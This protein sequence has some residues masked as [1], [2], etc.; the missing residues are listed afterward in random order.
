MDFS[1]ALWLLATDTLQ[2][3]LFTAESCLPWGR[4]QQ[5]QSLSGLKMLICTF[6]RKL[7]FIKVYCG[8]KLFTTIGAAKKPWWWLHMH[9][10]DLSS[11]SSYA[12]CV[13]TKK[14]QNCRC[15]KLLDLI[16]LMLF[17]SIRHHIVKLQAC[18]ARAC[19]WIT[20]RRAMGS[21]TPSSA[22]FL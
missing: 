7:W 19:W 12:G 16:C 18:G 8:E 5:R 21:C 1:H 13:S 11:T 2:L 6:G 10:D 3:F 15:F 22:S 4:K 20:Q 14:A 9:D 17:P